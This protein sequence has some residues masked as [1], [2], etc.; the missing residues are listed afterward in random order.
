[1]R[2]SHAI[3]KTMVISKIPMSIIQPQACGRFV[4]PASPPRLADLK[5]AELGAMP[6]QSRLLKIQ[7]AAI[8]AMKNDMRS[9]RPAMVAIM[10]A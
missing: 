6:R 7:Y 4:I 3:R 10:V 9:A 8:T 1:V 5:G 2:S